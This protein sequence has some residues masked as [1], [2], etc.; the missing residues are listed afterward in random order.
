MRTDDY[1]VGLIAALGQVR[2]LRECYQSGFRDIAPADDAVRRLCACL[3][4]KDVVAALD[5]LGSRERQSPRDLKSITDAQL[6]WEQT[7]GGSFGFGRREVRRYT[8]LCVSLPKWETSMVRT[9]TD[10][11]YYLRGRHDK[12]R[13]NFTATGSRGF[14][15]RKRIKRDA[16]VVVFSV[17]ILLADAIHRPDL[18]ISYCLFNLLSGLG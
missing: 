10:L 4:T 1:R 11:I 17:G 16:D 6:R 14:L 2:E 15:E 12:I 8:G 3:T 7:L 13:V 18:P 5:Q 9:A